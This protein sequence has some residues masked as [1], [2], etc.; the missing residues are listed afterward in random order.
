[1]GQFSKRVAGS[2]VE[3]RESKGSGN[4]ENDRLREAFF[5]ATKFAGR[6]IYRN[7]STFQLY[8]A[9]SLVKEMTICRNRDVFPGNPDRPKTIA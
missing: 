6:N 2:G 1:M 4:R 3:R 5:S 8:R 7:D 9:I